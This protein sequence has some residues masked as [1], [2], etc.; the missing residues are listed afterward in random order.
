MRL[1]RGVVEASGEAGKSSGIIILFLLVILTLAFFLYLF[2]FFI[3]VQVDN[4]N[5]NLVS[6]GH[7]TTGIE[8]GSFLTFHHS[9]PWGRNLNFEGWTNRR[10]TMPTRTLSAIL[11]LIMSIYNISYCFINRIMILTLNM[12]WWDNSYGT[13]NFVWIQGAIDWSWRWG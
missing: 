13:F 8:T 11:T 9:C 7:Y 10:G 6:S 4:K 2:H 3:N 5:L 1:L 12:S